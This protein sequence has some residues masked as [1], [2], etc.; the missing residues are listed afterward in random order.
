[1]L[2]ILLPFPLLQ[3]PSFPMYSVTFSQSLHGPYKIQNS[4]ATYTTYIEVTDAVIR[5]FDECKG[6]FPNEILHEMQM[7]HP[8][9]WPSTTS[10]T[11]PELPILLLKQEESVEAGIVCKMYLELDGTTKLGTPILQTVTVSMPDR[12]TA[13]YQVMVDERR[14]IRGDDICPCGDFWCDDNCGTLSCGCIDQ[15]RCGPV[16]RRGYGR[17]YRY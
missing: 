8:H 5:Y 6:R 11:V 10:Y 9:S 2:P 15:C 16:Y 12:V 13:R 1:L 17:G 14:Q 4:T 7:T 3:V